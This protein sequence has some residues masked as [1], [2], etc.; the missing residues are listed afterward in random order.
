MATTTLF[1]NYRPLK[2]GFCVKENNLG[3]VVRAAELNTLL[4][5]GIY[6][7]I[8]PVG[9][10]NKLASQ[11]VKLFQVDLLYPVNDCS[12]VKKF[13]EEHKNI[14][15]PNP[16]D[17]L[18]FHQ[19]ENKLRMGV[20]DI[21]NII[22]NHWESEFKSIKRSNCILPVWNP[23]DPLAPVFALEFGIY[24]KEPKLTFDH[25]IGYLKGLR[26]KV[27]RIPKG[28]PLDQTIY[29]RMV[30]IFL[31]EDELTL[32]NGGWGWRNHGVFLGQPNNPED[33]I[34]FWNL[35]ASGIN[36]H[37]VPINSISRVKA[38]IKR[39]LDHV[40]KQDLAQRFPMGIGFWYGNKITDDKVRKVADKLIEKGKTRCFCQVSEHSWN[41][42]N[43]KPP[44]LEFENKTILANVDRPY[45][46]PS[47]SLQ[48]PEKPAKEQ[49]DNYGQ[50]L[51]V[52][53]NPI[54]E[55]EH[56]GYTIKLPFLP[57]LNE[58]YSRNIIFDPDKL[59][60]GKDSIGIITDVHDPTL[61]LHPIKNQEIIKQIFLRSKIEAKASKPGLIAQRLIERMGDLD[62]CRVFKIRGVRK[63]IASISPT[64]A[65]TRSRAEVLIRDPDA[66]G[67]PSFDNHESLFIQK[68]DTPKLTPQEVFDHL[69]ENNIF[70]V[71]LMPVCPNCE[72]EFWLSLRAADEQVKCEYCGH[73]FKIA[74]Q[75][76]HRGDF[77]FRR[78][79][80]FGRSDNQ[81]GSIPVIL[82]LLQFLKR[83]HMDRFMYTTG[84]KLESKEQGID[85]ELDLAVVGTK[86]FEDKVTMLIGECKTKDQITD[87][88]IGNMLKVKEILDNSGIETYL[89]FS[90]TSDFTTDEIKRFLPLAAKD[91]Y[92]IL[93]TATELEPYDLYEHYYDQKD[94]LPHPYTHQFDEMGLNSYEVYLKKEM[95]NALILHG[96][97]NNSRGNWF[98]WLKGELEKR[99]FNVWVPDLPASDKPNIKRYNDY[100]L[101]RRWE[102]NDK[103][104]LIGHS[105]G[106]VAVLGL[107]QHL[108]ENVIVDTCVLVASFKDNLGSADFNGLFEEPF[109]FEKIKKHAK[110]FI[111]IHSDDDP[112][113]PLDHAKFLAKKLG[114]KLIIKKGQGHFNLEKGPEYK[115]FPLILEVLG[116]K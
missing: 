1:I 25:R 91:I 2:I 86:S 98:P 115:Q 111:F 23:A 102:F 9:S 104:V 105:S 109:D 76:R 11:L 108:P 66:N 13:I 90:K 92:P 100:I 61:S 54:G 60:V 53:V 42:L 46:E 81:E 47:I 62:D 85:C 68:R 44:K 88:D 33:L 37:F 94:K 49:K 43:V 77:R 41:G 35:R 95:K 80:L 12:E 69:L 8:I 21:S 51:V 103:T 64:D 26:A 70:T 17:K 34:N 57:D 101:G 106:A 40:E 110:Q 18:L 45:G 93:F 7:P 74:V 87:Q 75:L 72:L 84:L 56:E 20:L 99:G 67:K 4:W 31:T 52:E 24:P 82:T 10:D 55:Y 50:D 63:L 59:R 107:L 83:S 79:G 22:D 97:G 30:P 58:W 39:H 113:C 36:L 96:T 65:I 27:Q 14:Q 89:L 112:Y 19:T 38:F 5:G 28:K 116:E 16:Y 73:E 114:G 15:W 78:S 48:L 6:N 3:D 71:G 29:R 32:S